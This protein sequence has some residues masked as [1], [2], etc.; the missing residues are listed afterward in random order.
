MSYVLMYECTCNTTKVI[1]SLKVIKITNFETFSGGKCFKIILC[2]RDRKSC[3][4]FWLSGLVGTR[5]MGPLGRCSLLTHSHVLRALESDR[6]RPPARSQT[7]QSNKITH[8]N[9]YLKFTSDLFI[10]LRNYLL[11]FFLFLFRNSPSITS[12]NIRSLG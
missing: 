3:E 11:I 1:K 8:V 10:F 6:H 4:T 2:V 5:R 7:N 12:K 9:D